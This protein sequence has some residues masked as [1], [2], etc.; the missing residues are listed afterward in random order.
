MKI[1][2]VVLFVLGL[3]ILGGLTV[4]C[5]SG[6][7]PTPLSPVPTSTVTATVTPT[8]EPTPDLEAERN[9]ALAYLSNPDI[10]PSPTP[11]PPDAENPFCSLFPTATLTPVPTVIPIPI[12][13]TPPPLPGE[14]TQG[15]RAL[16]HCAGETEEYWLEHGPPNMTTD[17]VM[18]LNA[19]LEAN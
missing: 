17:L 11:C 8:P 7:E 15:V 2:L 4:A 18:C 1:A 12:P 5:S 10:Y 3:L 14:L 16:V 6:S 13:G 19:Y 9:E